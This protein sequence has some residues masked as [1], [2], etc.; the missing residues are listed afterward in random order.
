VH[1]VAQGRLHGGTGL[2]GTKDVDGGNGRAGEVGRDVRRDDSQPENLNVQGFSSGVHRLQVRPTIL[3]Q[4]QAQS[5]PCD[6]LLDCIFVAIELIADC[7]PYEIG[8]VGVK[9]PCTSRSIWPRS[10]CPRLIVIFSLSG[11]FGR[12]SCTFPA[13]LHPPAIR[14][15]GI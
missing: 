5:V 6:R 12:S 15:D 1:A 3:M 13:I 14:W 2:Q 4:T 7:R 9:A 10:T 11:A 8:A